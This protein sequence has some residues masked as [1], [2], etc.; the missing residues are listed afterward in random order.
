MNNDIVKRV[1]EITSKID[2]LKVKKIEDETNAKRLEE[3]IAEC[4]KQL[5]ELGYSSIEEAEKSVKEL[6]ESLTKECA[7]IESKLSSISI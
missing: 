2:S 4:D 7:D 3:D 6:E 5:K 1:Q